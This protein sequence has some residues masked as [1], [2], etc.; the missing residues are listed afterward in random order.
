MRENGITK[1]WLDI[2]DQLIEGKF[3]YPDGRVPEYQPWKYGEPDDW[4]G[5]DFADVELLNN[6]GLILNDINA[7]Q[8]RSVICQF[9]KI[10]KSSKVGNEGLL[11]LEK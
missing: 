8:Q 9:G 11:F 6:D 5:E 10:K 2:S 4:F 1:A 7:H 3:V